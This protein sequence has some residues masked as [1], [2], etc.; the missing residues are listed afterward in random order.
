M[1]LQN[2]FHIGV[3]EFRVGI[4]SRGSGPVR[5]KES[6]SIPSYSAALQLSQ[7]Y[8]LGEKS[9]RTAQTQSRHQKYS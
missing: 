2:R 8:G 3:L 5:S 4:R 9:S 7:A 1:D 6:D